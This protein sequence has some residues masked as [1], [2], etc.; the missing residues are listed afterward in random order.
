[1]RACVDLHGLTP[2]GNGNVD[3]GNRWIDRL[4]KSLGLVAK[5]LFQL[6]L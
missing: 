2:H 3:S 4:T 5:D 1:M 6:I